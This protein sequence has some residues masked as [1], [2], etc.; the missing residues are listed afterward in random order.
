[1]TMTTITAF[2]YKLLLWFISF[3][4]LFGATLP[5][6]STD[7]P[8][9]VNE[10]AAMT[11]VLWGDTQL[12]DYDAKR[13]LYSKNA[14][15]DLSNADGT[16]DA[17]VIAGDVTEN[18]KGAEYQLLLDYLSVAE[19]VDHH[20]MTVGNHDV[21]LRSYSQVV[22]TFDEFCNAANSNFA[23]NAKY[24]K[25]GKLSYTYEVN[26]YTFIV[27]GTD[28][29]VFEESY[30]SDECLEWFDAELNKATADGKPVFV[31]VHQPLKQTHQ[32]WQSWNS[33]DDNAGTIGKQSDE[34]ETIME[35]YEN[36]FFITGHLHMGFSEEWSI[37]NNGKAEGENGKVTLVNLPGIGPKNADG[38]TY[39]ESGTGY[40]ME[41]YDDR[42][43][44]IARDF[45]LGKY[46]PDHNETVYFK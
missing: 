45:N 17:L 32:V 40:I 35:K 3:T 25:E 24:Y 10:D 16:F 38:D 39:N 43:E 21:R 11:V 30:I 9:K 31:V 29:V 33:P 44:F 19:N 23:D 7:E 26:G 41:V 8:I 6:P 46:V 14:A 34:L 15:I 5:A 13:H 36:V 20:I 28:K 42:V 12:S 1:M 2:M 4:A 27:L 37:H 22:K 18:G